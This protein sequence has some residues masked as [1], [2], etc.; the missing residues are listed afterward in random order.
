[1]KTYT[2]PTQHIIAGTLT[3]EV[4]TSGLTDTTALTNRYFS[5]EVVITKETEFLGGDL[6]CPNADFIIDHDVNDMFRGTILRECISE[7]GY[8]LTKVTLGS[9]ILFYGFVEPSTISFD[10]FYASNDALDGQRTA[11]RF[12]SIWLMALAKNITKADFAGRLLGIAIS[13][14]QYLSSSGNYL[15][16]GYVY[17]TIRDIIDAV[18]YL[19]NSEYGFTYR[20]LYELTDFHF[21]SKGNSALSSDYNFPNVSNYG[22]IDYGGFGAQAEPSLILGKVNSVISA[23][24]MPSGVYAES[25]TLFYDSSDNTFDNAYD[26]FVGILKS[27]GL[28]CEITHS[29]T[30]DLDV[31][32][33]TRTSGEE[34]VVSDILTAKEKPMSDLSR[35]SINVRSMTSG[36]AYIKEFKG[37]GTSEFSLQLPYDFGNDYDFPGTSNPANSIKSLVMPQKYPVIGGLVVTTGQYFELIRF[38]GLGTNQIVNSQFTTNLDDWTVESGTWVWN[39]FDI[40][41]GGG[42]ARA[43][44]NTLDLQVISQTLASP[45][46][47]GCIWGGWFRSTYS[48]NITVRVM[49]YDGATLVGDETF[50]IAEANRNFLI[51][52]TIAAGVIR[53]NGLTNISKVAIQVQGNFSA[54]GTD[55]V[56]MDR[57]F[58]HR[59]RKGTPELVGLQ[60]EDYFNDGTLSEFAL[61]AN[62]IQ[63]TAPRNYFV[64]NAENFYYKKIEL[65]LR[66]NETEIEAINYQY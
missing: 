47:D 51:Y 20:L 21:F 22:D 32:I 19:L 60:V 11:I 35:S 38:V 61:T 63:D 49:M 17:V 28:Y 57:M 6:Q 27:F 23:T 14:A 24:G 42:C 2:F 50:T 52:G 13:K 39:A 54:T 41:F 7:S 65:Q 53:R 26:F 62:G 43:T 12:R 8:V 4:K 36:N 15:T 44:I 59:A 58:F 40:V 16:D 10:P 9:D 64:K 1:M 56:Y 33:G 5:D 55:Y 29:S 37:L 48:G 25:G 3:F 18:F 30:Y 34:I 45:L 46:Y 66:N 31:R